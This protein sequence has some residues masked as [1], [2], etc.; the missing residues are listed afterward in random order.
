MTEATPIAYSANTKG[1]D[2]SRSRNTKFYH[3]APEVPEISIST[4]KHIARKPP[5]TTEMLPPKAQFVRELERGRS[6][7]ATASTPLNHNFA[8]PSPP[9]STYFASVLRKDR[10]NQPLVDEE[11]I[12]PETAG[13]RKSFN[14]MSY[15]QELAVMAARRRRKYNFIAAVLVAVV[16][17]VCGGM[18][19][20]VLVSSNRA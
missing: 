8:S 6:K 10:E 12:Q 3:S 9:N 15:R 1:T 17:L 16:L 11:K 18:L 5:A 13:S 19:A 2:P 7:S 4:P 20:F 14:L